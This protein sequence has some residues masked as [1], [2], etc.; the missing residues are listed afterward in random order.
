ML[1]NYDF[2]SSFF[3]L[4]EMPTRDTAGYFADRKSRWGTL[5]IPRS[6]HSTQCLHRRT[7]NAWWWF[8]PIW[9]IICGNMDVLRIFL[10]VAITK[11]LLH[12]WSRASHNI[13]IW[14]WSS[15]GPN[16]IKNL[17]LVL[18][19]YLFKR[20]QTAISI[21]C[22]K[23]LIKLSLTHFPILDVRLD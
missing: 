1:S 20:F 11:S 16:V 6:C 22:S 3:F 2:L 23:A 19:L 18:Q 7:Q 9:E 12:F 4:L 10:S 5:D 8:D 14:F 15:A 21:Q 17:P 13:C